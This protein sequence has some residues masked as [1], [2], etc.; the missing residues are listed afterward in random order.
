MSNHTMGYIA[1]KAEQKKK[2]EDRQKSINK[3]KNEAF[4]NSTKTTHTTIPDMRSAYQAVVDADFTPPE[5]L[6]HYQRFTSGRIIDGPPNKK[7]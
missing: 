2:E 3:L 4:I 6:I 7:K 5:A 1:L